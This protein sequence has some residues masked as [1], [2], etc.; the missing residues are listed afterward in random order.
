MTSKFL[1]REIKFRAGH[2][3][4]PLIEKLPIPIPVTR[5]IQTTLNNV[6]YFT[7]KSPSIIFHRVDHR[8][9]FFAQLIRYASCNH[10]IHYKSV[11]HK[12]ANTDLYFWLLCFDDISISKYFG[13]FETCSVPPLFGAFFVKGNFPVEFRDRHTNSTSVGGLCNLLVP[14]FPCPTGFKRCQSRP[15]NGSGCKDCRKRTVK[16]SDQSLISVNG[17]VERRGELPQQEQ[18]NEASS[19]HGKDRKNREDGN[20]GLPTHDVSALWDQEMS[21]GF[22]A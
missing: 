9:A 6:A 16:P 13:D 19:C 10:I 8:D 3:I 22:I 21:H 11:F 17:C 12:S 7:L 5:L 14:K 1:E 15:S 4:R 18:G 2:S 20:Q